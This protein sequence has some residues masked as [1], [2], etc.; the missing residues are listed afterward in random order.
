MDRTELATAGESQFKTVGNLAKDKCDTVRRKV[1][2]R[3]QRGI[4]MELGVANAGRQKFLLTIA[5]P[6]G[7]LVKSGTF[8]TGG[9]RLHV[10]GEQIDLAIF[11]IV[12]EHKTA[13]SS[14][15]SSC[16]SRTVEPSIS[17]RT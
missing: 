3:D 9:N 13:S 6:P 10:G 17:H 12:A 7:K 1:N 11:L 14:A 15:P 16:H 4:G 8:C 2:K 5:R